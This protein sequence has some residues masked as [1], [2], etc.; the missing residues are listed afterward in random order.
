MLFRGSMRLLRPGGCFAFTMD[1]LP[2]CLPPVHGHST[3]HSKHNMNSRNNRHN[4]HH[5][6]PKRSSSDGTSGA[7]SSLPYDLQ[8]TG[9]WAHTWAYVEAQVLAAGF[10]ISATRGL[11]TTAHFAPRKS[12]S[13]EVPRMPGATSL[14][15]GRN[16]SDTTRNGS[17]SSSSI[18]S[19]WLREVPQCAL[20]VVLQRHW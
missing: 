6:T 14:P 9:R 4:M 11:N 13:A 2:P 20:A 18:D 15:D 17:N 5:E 8:P 3:N 1:L 10:T 19:G 16:S 7:L 12:E